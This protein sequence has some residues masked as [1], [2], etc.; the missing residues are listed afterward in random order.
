MIQALI[1]NFR[2]QPNLLGFSELIMQ[3]HGMSEC[4]QC[5][6][7]LIWYC[8]FVNGEKHW[9]WMKN[10]AI[11]LLSICGGLWHYSDIT[12]ASWWL[13]SLATQLFVQQLFGLPTK[14]ISKLC[15][16][17]L[18]GGESTG[19]QWIPL[20][21]AS[22]QW[23]VDSLYKGP[24]MWKSFPCHDFF[25]SC[26]GGFSSQRA[27]KPGNISMSYLNCIMPNHEPLITA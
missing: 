23:P 24:I 17:G 13:K 9:E 8:Q 14:K 12:W 4:M 27:S 1:T 11:I 20:T 18:L 16:T 5:P 21:R 19:H 26:Y 6:P 22:R 2:L 15:V 25:M 7:Y 3:A 10:L